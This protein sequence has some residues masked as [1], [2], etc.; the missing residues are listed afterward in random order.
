MP[1]QLAAS[2]IAHGRARRTVAARIGRE[3]DSRDAASTMN[4]FECVI[5]SHI[6]LPIVKYVLRVLYGG[7]YYELKKS[8]GARPRRGCWRRQSL[9][10]RRRRA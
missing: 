10:P 5:T 7:L 2:V 1:E 9:S 8:N 4:R 6:D 3:M